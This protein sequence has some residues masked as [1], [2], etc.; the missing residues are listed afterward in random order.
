MMKLR[1]CRV[2]IGR[3]SEFRFAAMSRCLLLVWL[4]A[5]LCTLAG[6]ETRVSASPQSPHAYRLH[7]GDMIE[8]FYRL[9]PEYN[10]VANILPDGYVDLRLLGAIRVGGLGVTEARDA[11]VAEASKR[12]KNPQV[13]V[14]VLDFVPDH[15]MVIGEVGKPGR[16][17]L[18]GPI[19]AVEALAIA[20]G[21]TSQSSRTKVILVRPLS[22]N[23]EYGQATVINFKDLNRLKASVSTKMP[24]MLNGDV[25][26]VTTSKTAKVQNVI[27]LA[28]IGLYYN[29]L[30][31][32]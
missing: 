29:P 12:L 7:P 9:T 22:P 5:G 15:F 6:Q 2:K 19:N 10:Q 4:M 16:Y 27:R 14:S 18:R 24:A 26:I 1:P 17:E 31:P 28:N 3:N 30:P 25:L 32:I 8:V 13:S 11:I 20:G 23:S 21:F